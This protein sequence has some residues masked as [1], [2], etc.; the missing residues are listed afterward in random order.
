MPRRPVVRFRERGGSDH[1]CSGAAS[2]HASRFLT[3]GDI[4][5]MVTCN[6]V[7]LLW[8][9]LSRVRATQ[10]WRSDPV[11]RSHTFVTRRC[12]FESP[13]L[14]R[15]FTRRQT[16]RQKV[17]FCVPLT[18][19][20]NGPGSVQNGGYRTL[21]RQFMVTL[22]KYWLVAP[23]VIGSGKTQADGFGDQMGCAVQRGCCAPLLSAATPDRQ[24]ALP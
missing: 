1:A 21:P 2:V 3:R 20:T 18:D 16:T 24:W 6:Q 22:R 15:T 17:L 7:P 19:R 12:S 9:W 11:D 13:E 23:G 14:R 5:H 8:S 10:G 4:P